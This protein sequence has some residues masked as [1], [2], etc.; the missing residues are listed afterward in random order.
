MQE[1]QVCALIDDVFG[2]I[3]SA[4]LVKVEQMQ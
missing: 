2:G 1:L 4:N 3:V